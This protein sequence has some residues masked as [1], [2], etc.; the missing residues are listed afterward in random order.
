MKP[1]LKRSVGS[2]CKITFLRRLRY[3]GHAF[4][5][6]EGTFVMPSPMLGTLVNHGVCGLG[7]LLYVGAAYRRGTLTRPPCGLNA[8]E[9]FDGA[10]QCAVCRSGITAKPVEAHAEECVLPREFLLLEAQYACIARA[11][12]D[13]FFDQHFLQPADWLIIIAH[14]LNRSLNLRDVIG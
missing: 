5:L 13:D 4:E 1:L 14:L 9:V 6:N 3:L 11:L 8:R 12:N 7:R 10:G 2:F